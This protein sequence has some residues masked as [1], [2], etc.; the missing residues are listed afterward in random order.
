MSWK[1]RREGESEI[2]KKMFKVGWQ[3][4]NQFNLMPFLTNALWTVVT[5]INNSLKP[6][7]LFPKLYQINIYLL[8]KPPINIYQF[9]G[10]ILISFSLV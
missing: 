1:K 2:A 8:D 10:S 9:V 5:F 6:M 3:E 4:L 7:Q